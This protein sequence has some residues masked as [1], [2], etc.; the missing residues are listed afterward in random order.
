MLHQILPTPE[1][2]NGVILYD[3]LFDVANPDQRLMTQMSAQVT[4]M[5]AKAENVVTVPT[6][7]V[8]QRDGYP[9][10]FTVD[11]NNVARRLRVRTGAAENGRTEILEGIQA[12]DRVVERGAGFLG[13]GDVVRV[14]NE[15][16][17]P[18]Q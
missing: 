8:V 5:V 14:V 18:A 10:V 9:Y 12:G 7:A 2:V 1:E 11:A 16:A 17:G 6:A 3:A 4:F 15:A 13:D